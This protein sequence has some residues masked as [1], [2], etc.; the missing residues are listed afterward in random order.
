[1]FTDLE[2]KV[3]NVCTQVWFPFNMRLK[4]FSKVQV[5]RSGLILIVA[6]IYNILLNLP[7]PIS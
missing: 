6:I 3:N 1:M 7:V 2:L 5:Q 4:H